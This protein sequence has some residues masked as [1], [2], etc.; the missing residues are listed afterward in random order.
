[1]RKVLNY[2]FQLDNKTTPYTYED[3]ESEEVIPESMYVTKALVKKVREYSTQN[4]VHKNCIYKFAVESFL[5]N[6]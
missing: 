3:L 1:M 6:H 4:C 5:K 2:Y